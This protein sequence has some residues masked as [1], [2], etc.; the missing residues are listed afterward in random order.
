M[1]VDP[2]L[3][4]DSNL[5]GHFC[6]PI[7]K[8]YEN[9]IQWLLAEGQLIVCPSLI[10]EYHDAVRGS[11]RPTS[12]VVLIGYLQREGRLKQCTNR[13][14][15]SFVIPKH[16]RKRLLSNRRD[17]DFLKVILLSDRKLGLSED[18][19]LRRDVN[20]YP[21]YTAC[22]GAHPSEVEYRTPS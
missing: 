17:H 5:S 18:R 12:L 6:R 3:F 13:E 2:D 7:D 4:V 21:G 10:R 8:A 11:D 9:L 14:L 22:V 20:G 19:N 1:T 15:S 16:R